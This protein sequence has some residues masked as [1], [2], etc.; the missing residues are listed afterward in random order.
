[1]IE[2]E[3]LNL[4]QKVREDSDTAARMELN[5]LLRTRSDAR[6]SIAH[7]LI[8]EQVLIGYLRD[9]SIVSILDSDRE[10]ATQPSRKRPRGGRLH[11]SQQIAIALIAGM[12]VGLLGV[13]V[14]WAVNSPKS[15][16][17]EI[18]V[19]N[20]DFEAFAGPLPIGFPSDFGV[21]SGN[22]SEVVEEEDGNRVLRLLKTANVNGEANDLASNCSVFQLVDLSTLQQQLKMRAREM[23]VTLNFTARFRREAALSDSE[24]PNLVGVSRI[25]LFKADPGKISQ[26]WPR[27]INDE[28]IGYG[29]KVIKLLPGEDS[30]TITSSCLLESEA[31]VALLVVSAKTGDLA[32]PIDLGGYYIDDLRLNAIWQPALPIEFV[33]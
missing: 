4:L 16:A 28:G 9:E 27:V 11:R 29:R 1:M 3:L 33:N 25:F 15:Q 20:G 32:P 30:A 8:N 7:L 6:S 31:S 26:S 24:F 17:Q 21:W 13:G 23:Q 5:S 18:T 10:P 22:P 19:V 12:F 14:V 2:E